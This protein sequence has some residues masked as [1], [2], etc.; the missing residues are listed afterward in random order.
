MVRKEEDQIASDQLATLPPTPSWRLESFNLFVEHSIKMLHMCL[1]AYFTTIVIRTGPVE[2]S[3]VRQ[4]CGPPKRLISP[5]GQPPAAKV[6][7]SQPT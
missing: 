2:W 7:P 3:A 4:T 5:Q 1:R 6:A